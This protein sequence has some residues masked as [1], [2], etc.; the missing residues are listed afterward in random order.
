M[1][2]DFNQ[3]ALERAKKE[4][5]SELRDYF[6]DKAKQESGWVIV[7]AL[8]QSLRKRRFTL[9]QVRKIDSFIRDTFEIKGSDLSYVRS[10]DA[11]DVGSRNVEAHAQIQIRQEQLF[12][13]LFLRLQVA[14]REQL[15]SFRDA[16]RLVKEIEVGYPLVHT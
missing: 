3:A 13:E 15:L 12:Q 2:Y 16:C 10:F 11:T 5:V 1:M 9:G 7:N 8:S 6:V 4:I 14:V